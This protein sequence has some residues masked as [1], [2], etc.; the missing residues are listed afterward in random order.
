MSTNI[1][2]GTLFGI[3]TPLLA[4]TSVST[5][6]IAASPENRSELSPKQQH[7]IRNAFSRLD[8][9]KGYKMAMEWRD[10]K[11][12]SEAMCRPTALQYSRKQYPQTDRV[13][14]GN[15]ENDGL[16][17]QGNKR[18]SGTGQFRKRTNWHYFTFECQQNP[19]T[20]RAASFTANITKTE[21]L[22]HQ[23]F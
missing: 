20:D 22:R 14:L 3:A 2:S 8:S 18:L 6:D 12:V 11:K 4:L 17:L 5:D 13:F 1:F 19:A 23:S 21:S 10:A 15:R 7:V 9:G 16:K